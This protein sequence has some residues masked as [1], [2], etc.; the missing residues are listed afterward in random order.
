MAVSPIPCHAVKVPHHEQ[1][2]E[3]T[4]AA[5]DLCEFS[6]RDKPWDSHK[7]AVERVSGVY[8]GDAALRR[9]GVRMARCAD[10]L[11]FGWECHPDHYGNPQSTLRLRH[12]KFCRVR[13][14]PIC[15][16][17]RSMLWRARLYQALPSVL[18][19]NPSAKWLFLTLTVRNC[20]MQELRPTLQ[21]MNQAWRRLCL[22]PEFGQVLGWLRTTEV[23]RGRDGHSA[24]PHFHCLLMVRSNMLTKNYVPQSRWVELWQSCAR[25][26]YPP[27]VDVRIVRERHPRPGEI[28][29]PKE[30]EGLP[31]AVARAVAEVAKYA[32]K[33]GD[34]LMQ[35]DDG[36]W[37][38]E[39][40]R[41]THKLRFVAS[42]GVLKDVLKFVEQ[43]HNDDLLMQ[44][45]SPSPSEKPLDFH[46]QTVRQRYTLF[47]KE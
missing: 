15:Q 2:N 34:M 7:S 3:A 46:W 30:V 14:C 40:V 27:V 22:R 17:R 44:K 13:H 19:A 31:A 33:S 21:A 28:P 26:D 11:G 12:A 5:V 1:S 47:K 24:H 43:E 10:I 25:L 36:Q 42:G 6:E 8:L 16:W 20:S 18:K 32:T 29:E 23:T 39:M 4:S 35:K 41:Q 37:L 9:R 38:K 45:S